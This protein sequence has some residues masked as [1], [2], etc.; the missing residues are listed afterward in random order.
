MRLF[1]RL[2]VIFMFMGHTISF[3]SI[4]S[5]PFFFFFLI[6]LFL[7]FFLSFFL[8]VWFT[9][10]H[11][12]LTSAA[13]AQLYYRGASEVMTTRKLPTEKA[14]VSAVC[15]CC[16]FVLCGYVCVMCV[17]LC[18]VVWLCV[19]VCVFVTTNIL[20]LICCVCLFVCC[21]CKLHNILVIKS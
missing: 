14:L 5:H 11:L 8:G 13:L 12:Q 20:Q 18:V 9:S 17:W 6:H 10:F 2:Y 7:T 15:L 16:A 1:V 3:S 4:A 21:C 19:C